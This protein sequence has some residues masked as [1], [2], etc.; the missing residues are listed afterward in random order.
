MRSLNLPVLA[1]TVAS[2]FSPVYSQQDL[3]T[4]L[5]SHP[6]T[7]EYAKLLTANPLDLIG[8]GPFL[9]LA[10]NNQAVLGG[11]SSP[12][13]RLLR[14]IRRAGAAPP[15]QLL[16]TFPPPDPEAE[17]QKSKKAPI[18]A[19][20][21]SSIKP[22][23]VPSA[24]ASSAAPS[25][26]STAPSSSITATDSSSATTS[27][28]APT[29]TPTDSSSATTSSPAPTSTDPTSWSYES[30]LKDVL[31][32]DVGSSSVAASS[33]VTMR[34]LMARQTPAPG[35]PGPVSCPIT[36]L[37]M[38]KKTDISVVPASLSRPKCGS[39]SLR[40]SGRCGRNFCCPN[41]DTNFCCDE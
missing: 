12:S 19:P 24:S 27:S 21:S 7:T 35:A 6:N 9:I 37:L 26:A 17:A 4:A 31:G 5:A 38:T 8:N 11:T 22:Q 32:I 30:F 10:P 18:A 3:I 23:D 14:Y 1:L 2:L 16:G 13:A 41:C 34:R 28:P 20:S 15:D 25:D 36:P 40:G 33:A 29:S 39:Y